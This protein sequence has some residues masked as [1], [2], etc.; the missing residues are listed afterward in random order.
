LYQVQ[1]PGRIE[2]P[3]VVYNGEVNDGGLVWSR[4][5]KPFISTTDL[6]IV[7][8]FSNNDRSARNY[9]LKV[10]L[11]PSNGIGVRWSPL[12]D[13]TA[14]DL[15]DRSNFE[16]MWI[17]MGALTAT[18]EDTVFVEYSCLTG[19]LGNHLGL[20]LII[21]QTWYPDEGHPYLEQ[22]PVGPE[23]NVQV[24][25][26][27]DCSGVTAPI[28]LEVDNPDRV[29]VVGNIPSGISFVKSTVTASWAIDPNHDIPSP[30][31]SPTQSTRH[32][33]QGGGE[34]PSPGEGG[35]G[36]GD[37]NDDPDAEG[38]SG[39]NNDKGGI[40]TTK[41]IIIIT[42]AAVAVI[43]IIIVIVLVVRRK[44][45]SDSESEVMDNVHRSLQ[46]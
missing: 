2:A 14:P 43:I 22:D 11:G 34:T 16:T 30:A 15:W 33:D 32:P 26:S 19:G 46:P 27:G 1:G 13:A 4:I 10:Q 23:P 45:N 3:E 37:G 44:K 18:L 12:G 29:T 41:I 28:R 25:F 24:L 20:T 36:D 17:W 6:K 39:G 5:L 38:E 35:S 21:R 40:S 8:S 42:V 9:S 31:Q 7:D